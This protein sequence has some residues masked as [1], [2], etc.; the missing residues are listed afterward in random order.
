M[1][2]RLLFIDNGFYVLIFIVCFCFILKIST[3]ISKITAGEKVPIS[4][5]SFYLQ[6]YV[7]FFSPERKDSLCL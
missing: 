5:Y 2:E 6:S 1:N 3:Y 4:I 7:H